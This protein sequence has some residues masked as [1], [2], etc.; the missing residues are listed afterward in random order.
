M[1]KFLVGLLTLTLALCC[2]TAC[3][4]D[5]PFLSGGEGGSS[6]SAVIG[7]SGGSSDSSSG[8]SSDSSSGGTED[9]NGGWTGIY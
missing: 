9:E 1:K 2:L 4:G 3:G 8:G 7:G 6:D 5:N